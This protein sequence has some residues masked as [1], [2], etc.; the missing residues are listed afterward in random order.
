MKIYPSFDAVWVAR[1]FHYSDTHGRNILGPVAVRWD[2]SN[3]W[4]EES[5][6]IVGPFS[7]I[8]K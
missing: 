4:E 3:T 8:T 6:R 1:T 5:I 7:R 2:Q